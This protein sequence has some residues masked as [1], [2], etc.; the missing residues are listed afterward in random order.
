MPRGFWVYIN[1]RRRRPFFRR[2]LV[3]SL[4][5]RNRQSIRLARK[6]RRRVQFLQD[7][8][9]PG[10]GKTASERRNASNEE[11]P[12]N[13]RA[14]YVEKQRTVFARALSEIRAGSKGSH[15]MWYV[16]PT[17]PFVMDG[18]ERGRCVRVGMA[19][20]LGVRGVVWVGTS[21]LCLMSLFNP[22][23]S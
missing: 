8:N 13:L 2:C 20:R 6:L 18:I 23:L 9:R 19:G 5:V 16:I 4:P 21:V 14:R 12:F 3:F 22:N 15:W 1:S 10:L 7:M 17:P 11:D